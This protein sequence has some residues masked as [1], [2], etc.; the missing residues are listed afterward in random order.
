[1]KQTR[2]GITIIEMLVVVSILSLLIGLLLPAIQASRIAA[3]R[4]HSSNNLR[5][6]AISL[7][8]ITSMSASPVPVGA[9][10]QLR[11]LRS[12]DPQPDFVSPILIAAFDAENRR[13]P[14]T[15]AVPPA[16]LEN[17]IQFRILLSQSDPSL[18]DFQG[19]LSHVTSYGWNFPVFMNAPRFPESILDGSSNT[20]M[21][22]ERY[23]FPKGKPPGAVKFIAD[24]YEPPWGSPLG[25]Q[26]M[27]Y[28]TERRATFADPVWGD[29]H[30]VTSGDPPVT[31]PS[32]PGVTFQVR[33][34]PEEANCH[35]LQT[36]YSA[37]LLVAMAD[38]SVRT[39]R[40]GISDTMFWAAITPRG[41]EVGTLD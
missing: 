8:N 34:R 39:I 4:M 23:Y 16:I 14:T 24:A 30:A 37:G 17:A 5:Q 1:M 11:Y 38:G 22:A 33:P 35:M 15:H 6:L 32:T 29:I 3:M 18:V 40:P 27:Y 26:D 21:F 7:H 31:R 41:G 12:G 9:N 28:N 36:P 13:I 2:N 10:G 25:P 20:I 19:S